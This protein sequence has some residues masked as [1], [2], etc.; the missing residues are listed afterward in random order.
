M[1]RIVVVGCGQV[2]VAY[3]YALLNQYTKVD[4]IIL[5]DFDNKKALGHA[6]DFSHTTIYSNSKINIKAGSYMDCKDADIVVITAGAI[7][8]P[9][10]NELQLAKKNKEIIKEITKMVVASGFKGIFVV[11]TSP[12]DIMTYVVKKYSKFSSNKVLGTGTLSDNARV[13][14][15]LSE[16][17]NVNPKDIELYTIGKC[18]DNFVVPWSAARVGSL[19]VL[20]LILKSDLK[21]IDKKAKNLLHSVIELKDEANFA[22]AS[23]L[24]RIT[25]AIV[26][27]EYALLPIS[28]PYEGVYVGMPT[29]INKDGIKG[30]MKI[31]LT[32][33]E[34][35]DLQDSIDNIKKTIKDLEV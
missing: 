3:V 18:G 8:K 24:A 7:G 29:V 2:G 23:S 11:A 21:Q 27:D 10:E 12:V 14:Y 5:I 31:K 1:N 9:N 28:A 20:D 16:K 13:K 4:E 17:L 33:E 32:N 22:L 15:I 26:N 34:A 6:M 30:V 19:D 25:N 35:N